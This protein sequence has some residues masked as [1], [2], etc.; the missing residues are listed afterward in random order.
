MYFFFSSSS[1]IKKRTIPVENRRIANRTDLYA[2][3]LQD[4]NYYSCNGA[5]GRKGNVVNARAHRARFYLRRFP[6]SSQTQPNLA[7]D[8]VRTNAASR[9]YDK[10]YHGRGET[11]IFLRKNNEKQVRDFL[12]FIKIFRNSIFGRRARV[13]LIHYCT[14]DFTFDKRKHFIR[15]KTFLIQTE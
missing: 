8:S 15:R 5:A 2:Q 9:N 3:S 12:N 13:T 14:A 10:L 11:E 6:R 4:R 1:L 7:T